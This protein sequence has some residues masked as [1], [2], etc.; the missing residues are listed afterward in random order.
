LTGNNSHKNKGGRP[1]KSDSERKN[2][3]I[4]VCFSEQEYI[5]IKQKASR[6]KLSLSEYCHSAVMDGKIVEPINQEDMQT[7]KSLSQMGN[8]LNQFVKV[9]RFAN[10]REMERAAVS[11]LEPMRNIIA[12]LSDDWKS[13]KRKKL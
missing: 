12:K 10:M 3:T 6:T 1:R 13:Y 11:L 8:N 7:L 4:A 5:A 2:K 9:S